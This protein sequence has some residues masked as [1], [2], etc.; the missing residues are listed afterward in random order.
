[1]L[2]FVCTQGCRE[3]ELSRIVS[4]KS[5]PPYPRLKMK[6]NIEKINLDRQDVGGSCARRRWEMPKGE[7]S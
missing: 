1:M 4:S 5:K 3:S 7:K 2:E 6:Y